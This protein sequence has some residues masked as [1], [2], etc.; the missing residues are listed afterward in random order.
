MFTRQCEQMAAGMG[1]EIWQAARRL[2]RTPVFTFAA[3]LTLALAIGAN[4]TIFAVVQRVVLNPLP[5]PASDELVRLDHGSLR[6]N[7]PSG[8]GMTTGLYYQYQRARTLEGV[9][10]YRAGE[11]TMVGTGEPERIQVARTTPTLASVLRVPPVLGRWFTEEEGD[12][13]A[14]PVTILSHGLWTRRFGGDVAVLGASITLDGVPA[15]VIG[16]MPASFAFPEPRTE[17]WLP[18]A[19]S[20]ATGFGL[21]FGYVGVGR[22]RPGATVADARAEL[23]TLIA[24]LPQAYPGDLGVLGNVAGD[25]ALRSTAIT[26]KEATVGD[27]SRALWI[28]LA[29]VGLVLLVACA[30]VANLFLVRS[31]A[32]Q[33]EVAVRRALGAS[34]GGIAR[35]FLSESMLLSAAG[36]VI[37]LTL[38]SG[39]VR[40]LVTLGPATL[41]RL[42]E[43]RLDTMAIAFTFAL[44]LLAALAFGS[45]PLWR[46]APLAASLHE[47]GRGN[48]ASRGRHRTRQMLMGGQ[49]ALALVLLIASGLMVRSFQNLRAFDPGFDATSALTFR[50]GLP[51]RAYPT[52]ASAATAHHAILDRL[53]TIPGVTAVS[54]ST[55]LPL[56]D[57]CFGNTILVQGR[58]VADGRPLPLARLC[59]VS[60]GYVAAMGVRLLRGR[61]IDRDDVERSQPNVVVNQAFVDIV[62]PAGD[63]IGQRIRS[64]APPRTT[65]RPEGA[66]SSAWDG[67]PPPWLTIV[68]IVSNTPFMALAERNPTPMVYMPMSIAGGPD[69]PAIA[70]LGPPVTAMSYVVR[71]T[72]SPSG[73]LPAVRDAID[74]VDPTLAV[75]RVSTL[76]DVLDRASA[77]MAFTMILLTIA[78]GVALLLGLIGIYGVISYIVSQRAGEIGVRIALGAQPGNV[79]G[80]IVRQGGTVALAGIAV[81]FSAALAGSRLVE[82]L[83]YDV[84]PRDPAIFAATTLTL[85]AVALLACWLP[86]RRAARIDPVETLRAG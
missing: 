37:G 61:G 51:D 65:P 40:L 76:E 49:V 32:R 56:A 15:T 82:S 21:P 79:A 41:P 57:A 83:L 68:G 69:I 2:G 81:G 59:A 11:S 28:L 39:A 4:A 22:L 30:N 38:A 7:V 62:F 50:I 52:R 64:N 78:A 5:Y 10:I 67:G 86:A 74:G 25:G 84:S 16:I 17:L 33:R 75:S 12:P 70:M 55:G 44:S 1:N 18:A 9:A 35:F 60:G 27:V 53:A 73:L 54:A 43:I 58:D 8:I 71:S 47:S 31:E 66:V 19:I 80:L 14:P 45:I 36:G 72:A 34:G 46:G 20:R 24:D 13:G 42:E 77:Q 26:L 48:T 3:A 6:I 23:N 63:P 29:A 85:L